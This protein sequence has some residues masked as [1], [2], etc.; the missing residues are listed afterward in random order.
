MK[1]RPAVCVSSKAAGLDAGR[2][3]GRLVRHRL[4]R[5]DRLAERH[6]VERVFG[7]FVRDP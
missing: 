2:D 3:V 1:A 5:R 4:E 6:S 7:G